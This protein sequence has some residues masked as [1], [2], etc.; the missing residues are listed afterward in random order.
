M[1]IAGSL[2]CPQGHTTGPYSEP[3]EPSSRLPTVFHIDVKK[4]DSRKTGW[5]LRD[6]MFLSGFMKNLFGLKV[7]M[8]R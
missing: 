6:M 1:Q 3:D 5:P 2:P 7:T 4:L 8:A